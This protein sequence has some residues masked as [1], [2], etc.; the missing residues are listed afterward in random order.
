MTKLKIPRQVGQVV[1]NKRIAMGI[2]QSQLAELSDTSRSLVY[3][4][5]K[6]AT[7]GV[8]FD[9]LFDVLKA[10]G[11]ELAVVDTKSASKGAQ[12]N[13]AD[14]EDGRNMEMPGTRSHSHRTNRKTVSKASSPHDAEAQF[15]E[16]LKAAR[17][18]KGFN[19]IRSLEG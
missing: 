5:E 15:E 17:N 6:G 4:V 8:A 14:M 16:E 19:V 12:K 18:I 3:R 9:K 1:K 11:L 13:A 7:N 10:L 2:S